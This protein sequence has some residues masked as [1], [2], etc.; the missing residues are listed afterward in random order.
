MLDEGTSTKFNLPL[1]AIKNDSVNTIVFS[2]NDA[3]IALTR[4]KLLQVR[5]PIIRRKVEATCK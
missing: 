1:A 3:T 5:P 2:S 4:E